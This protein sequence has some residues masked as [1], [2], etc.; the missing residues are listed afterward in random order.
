MSNRKKKRK[1]LNEEGNIRERNRVHDIINL[2]S[3]TTIE[4]CS[5]AVW[6]TGYFLCVSIGVVLV[7]ICYVILSYV[8]VFIGGN[9]C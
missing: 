5:L 3:N 2:I 7:C 8:T 1:T 6:R 4:L 9:R